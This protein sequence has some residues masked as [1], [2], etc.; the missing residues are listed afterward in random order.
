[1]A[2]GGI[3][4]VAQ[5]NSDYSYESM[6][7]PGYTKIDGSVDIEKYQPMSAGFYPLTMTHNS[8][9]AHYDDNYE[10]IPKNLTKSEESYTTHFNQ[11]MQIFVAPEGF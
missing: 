4:Q 7:T 5:L 8:E 11:Q 2:N 9:N 6:S 3:E 10:V 1:M